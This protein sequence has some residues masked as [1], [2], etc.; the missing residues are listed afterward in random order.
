M[1]AAARKHI[2]QAMSLLHQMDN[3]ITE[4]GGDDDEYGRRELAKIR[5]IKDHLRKALGVKEG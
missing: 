2:E 3:A 4:R 1:T 5:R